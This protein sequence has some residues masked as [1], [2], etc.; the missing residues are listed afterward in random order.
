MWSRN[1]PPHQGRSVAWPHWKRLCSR[2]PDMMNEKKKTEMTTNCDSHF[3]YSDVYQYFDLNYVLPWPIGHV[4]RVAGGVHA[5]WHPTVAINHHQSL[6]FPNHSVILQYYLVI[7]TKNETQK[8]WF[9]IIFMEF[10]SFQLDSGFLYMTNLKMDINL[11][12]VY[13]AGKQKQAQVKINE[14]CFYTFN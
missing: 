9:F 4:T 10:F 14:V 11:V 5:G 6:F 3:R 7:Q 12:W 1:A 13:N 2:L 8:L